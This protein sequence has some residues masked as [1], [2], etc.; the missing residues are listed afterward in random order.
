MIPAREALQRL[1]EGNERFTSDDRGPGM[2][3][4]QAARQDLTQ[5]QKPFAII[6]GCSDSRAPAELIFDQGLGELFVIRVAGNIAASSQI[7][8]VEF[9]AGH[10]GTRLVVVLGHSSCGA[11]SGALQ[12]LKAPGGQVS[13][14]LG[15]ILDRVRPAIEDLASGELA[16]DPE[17]LMIEAV[18]ANVRHAVEQLRKGSELVEEL[19][20][21]DGLR[22]VGGVYSLATGKVEFLDELP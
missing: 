4:T 18:K 1:V 20:R 16:D 3:T 13:P 8:S 21:D 7:G 19:I 9:A 22:V 6:L 11:V 14:G 5:G 17:A 2:L 15:S 10:L 12:A